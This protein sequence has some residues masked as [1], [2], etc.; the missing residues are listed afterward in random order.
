MSE[1]TESLETE[2][3]QLKKRVEE[4]LQENAEQSERVQT[5]RISGFVALLGIIL[6]LSRVQ[7]ALI[8]K[9]FCNIFTCKYWQLGLQV[10][11]LQEERVQLQNKVRLFDEQKDD[12][13]S[14]KDEVLKIISPHAN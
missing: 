12:Q 8:R 1:K 9:I 11:A 2:N 3:G 7:I 5:I 4:L 14:I 6:R 13:Q 10:I